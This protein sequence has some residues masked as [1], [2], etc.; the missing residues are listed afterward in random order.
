MAEIQI[1]ESAAAEGIPAIFCS[2]RVCREAWKNGGKDICLRTA[3][4]I[5]DR[6]RIDSGPDFIARSGSSRAMVAND[7]GYFR[8]E[9]WQFLEEKKF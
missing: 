1:P 3:Y 6:V 9:T 4:K 5:N 7:T 2:C 8:E